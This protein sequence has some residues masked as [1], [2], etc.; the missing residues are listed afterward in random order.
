MT[1]TLAH[2]L[3]PSRAVVLACGGFLD[4][5]RALGEPL[6]SRAMRAAETGGAHLRDWLAEAVVAPAG[7]GK[8]TVTA[9]TRPGAYEPVDTIAGI[10]VD[11]DLPWSAVSGGAAPVVLG[12]LPVDPCGMII[13]D[14]VAL[15]SWVGFL[16]AARS[17]DG[18]AD[19]RIGGR[20]AEE[21]WARYG[22]Q[23]LP[24][25]RNRNLHGWLDLPVTVAHE[26]AAAINEWALTRGHFVQMAYVEPHSH[27][28]LGSRAGRLDPLGAG[29]IEVAGCP[30]LCVGWAPSELQRF[31]AG[32]A[33]GQVYPV[34]LENVDGRATLR[35]TIP[36]ATG[37]IV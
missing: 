22:A 25:L 21:A 8:L 32:R 2:L 4:Q 15:D 5:W 24:G 11:L 6:S 17:V 12:D 19:V 36:P 37:P 18:L 20:G 35:W 7:P 28:H 13:G 23:P 16:P 30:V 33:F 34:T 14:A 26:R 27:H 1:A 29:V 9:R 3:V 31:S 10:D